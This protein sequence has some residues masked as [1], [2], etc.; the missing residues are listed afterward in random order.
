MALAV[1]MERFLATHLGGRQQEDVPEA[2]ARRLAEITVDV[3]TVERPDPAAR[4]L[5]EEA[6]RAPLPAASGK[7][8]KPARLQYAVT[9]AMGAQSMDMK[10]VRT[11]E[12]VKEKGRD[13]LRIT[14]ATEMA[15][16]KMTDSMV[17]ERA[18][19]RPVRRRVDG[20]AK[21]ELQYAADALTGTL[22]APGQHLDVN[23]PLSAPVFGDGP[24]MVLALAGLPLAEGY[25]TTLRQVS[26]ETQ[27]VE[28]YRLAV[29]GTET[30]E[31]P[32]GRFETFV[33]ELRPL[34]GGASGGVLRVMRKAPHHV[35]QAEYQ[36]PAMGGATMT[37]ALTATR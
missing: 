18:T 37:A 14:D 35:V 6:M 29:L 16:G 25:E 11:I 26:L 23:V 12:A 31:V 15:M 2:I 3:S 10:V 36:V 8:I 33:V 7:A 28:P 4:A 21:G 32:A 5:L 1:A 13:L 22:S 17:V 27:K 30:T 20:V 9:L 19:L 24:G 34:D